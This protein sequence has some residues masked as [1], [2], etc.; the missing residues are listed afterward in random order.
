MTLPAPPAVMRGAARVVTASA[1]AQAVE[2]TVVTSNHHIELNPS[3]AG[4]GGRGRRG[5][6]AYC[7]QSFTKWPFPIVSQ[8]CSGPAQR[9]SSSGSHLVPRFSIR[10]CRGSLYKTCGAAGR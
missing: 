5:H 8:S 1:V 4:A 2:L 9:I 6:S 7:V 10:S 3:D